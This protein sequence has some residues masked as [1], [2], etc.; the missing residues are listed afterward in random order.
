VRQRP[1]ETRGFGVV[2][3]PVAGEETIAGACRRV[4]IIK[5]IPP[6]VNF[7]YRFIPAVHVLITIGKRSFYLWLTLPD[8]YSVI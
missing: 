2:N 8:P 4:G 1:L 5:R 3:I 7:E 6:E